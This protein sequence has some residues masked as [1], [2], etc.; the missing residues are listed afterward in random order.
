MSTICIYIYKILFQNIQEQNQ[1]EKINKSLIYKNRESLKRRIW[2]RGNN[3]DTH[4]T[5]PQ[6]QSITPKIVLPWLFPDGD[7]LLFFYC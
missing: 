2:P 6:K 5:C 7:T 4:I 3:A 1:L